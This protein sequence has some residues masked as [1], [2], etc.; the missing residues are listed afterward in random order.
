[1]AKPQFV[2]LVTPKGVAQ[3]PKL[4]QPD[5]YNGDKHYKTGLILDPADDG[6]Q[7]FIDDITAK[8]QA[9]FDELEADA[10]KELASATGAKKAKLKKA[11]EGMELHTPIS[12]EYDDDGAETGRYVL[13][14][15]MKAAGVTKDGKAWSRKCPLFD[16]RGKDVTKSTKSLWGGSVLKLQISVIPFFMTGT[17]LGGV[18][19]RLEAVQIVELSAGG[20]D[21]SAFGIEEGGYCAEDDDTTDR[22]DEDI[23]DDASE[24]ED[25]S[26]F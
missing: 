10:Q 14:A 21:G 22:F 4:T 7:E 23:E 6:V 26:D 2:K 20:A 11:L 13:Q 8:A 15:K 5:E 9:A 3:W 1:M 18:S 12:P 17:Q 25:E 19:A 16:S 24:E